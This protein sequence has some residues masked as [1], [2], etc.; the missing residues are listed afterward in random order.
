MRRILAYECTDLDLDEFKTECTVR[1]DEF[2]CFALSATKFINSRKAQTYF[3]LQ[4]RVA[5]VQELVNESMHSE[6]K[7]LARRGSLINDNTEIMLVTP[8]EH[9]GG[10]P[11]IRRIKFEELKDY[12]AEEKN[13][14]YLSRVRLTF[15][16]H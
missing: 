12:L 4:K 8:S 10:I 6:K 5:I 3:L 13:K 1:S 14:Q 2:Y 15:E 16:T 9:T 11:E 7:K